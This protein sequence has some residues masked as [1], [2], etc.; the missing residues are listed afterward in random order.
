MEEITDMKCEIVTPEGLI[1]DETVAMVVV[2]GEMGELGI[3]PRHA[4]IVSR[5]VTGEARVKHKDGEGGWEFLAVGN[6]YMKVQ[7]DRLLLLVDT[8]EKAT[9]IDTARAETSLERAEKYLA[10][11]GEEGVDT[12]RAEQSR[13]RA[14]NRLKV[15]GKA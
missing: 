3:L 11:A 14:T 7:F 4:P 15:A 9:E 2:P 8:A 13:K 10:R 1:L 6:G 12:H 5:T